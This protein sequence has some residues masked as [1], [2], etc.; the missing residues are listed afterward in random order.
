MEFVPFVKALT[1]GSAVF[2]PNNDS[3]RHHVYSFSPVKT[4][5]LPL[6]VGTPANPV[7]FDKPGIV[8]MGCNIHD[9]MLGYIYV[10][11]SPYVATTGRK[12]AAKLGSLPAGRYGV[13]VWHPRMTESEESTHRVLTIERA[14]VLDVAWQLAVGPELRRRRPPMSDPRS[15]DYR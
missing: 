10:A 13:R 15:Y 11:D 1:V 8:T 14:S 3:V 7:V 6:Y 9:W 4:F 2:F 5:E 12:G